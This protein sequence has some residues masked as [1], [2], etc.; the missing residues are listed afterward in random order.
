[1]RSFIITDK[2]EQA[3]AYLQNKEDVDKWAKAQGFEIQW[4]QTGFSFDIYK[5]GNYAG[6]GVANDRRAVRQAL[7]DAAHGTAVE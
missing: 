7:N 2:H 5:G 4:E 3:F 1:M 6:Y